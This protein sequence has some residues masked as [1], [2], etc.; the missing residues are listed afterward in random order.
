MKIENNPIWNS[1]ASFPLNEPNLIETF[2]N[3]LV[4]T[5]NWTA[6]YTERV[7]MEYRKF[8]FLCA[9]SKCRIVPSWPVAMVWETHIHFYPLSWKMLSENLIRKKLAIST[10]DDDS[11]QDLCKPYELTR[12]AYID[13]FVELP[14]ADIWPESENWFNEDIQWALNV[15]KSR[16]LTIS[17]KWVIFLSV[18]LALLLA[19]ILPNNN[20]IFILTILA[21]AS[22][23]WLKFRRHKSILRRSDKYWNGN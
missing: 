1:I 15:S 3:R 2:P 21:V 13:I 9:T 23:S 18:V 7:M 10:I 4:K 14:P 17:V 11:W 20:F 5:F 6:G 22:A 8:L 12:D 16:T 19:M